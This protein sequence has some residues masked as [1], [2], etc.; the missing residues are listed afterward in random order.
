VNEF[1]VAWTSV[2]SSFFE[3][4][5]IY[6]GVVANGLFTAQDEPFNFQD[7]CA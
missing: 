4:F 1:P 2:N 7:S 5:A 6:T 3:T